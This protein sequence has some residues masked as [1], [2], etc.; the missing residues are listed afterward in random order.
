MIFDNLQQF[1]SEI[2]NYKVVHVFLDET[3]KDFS[4][5]IQQIEGRVNITKTIISPCYATEPLAQNLLYRGEDFVLVMGKLHLQSIAKF[6][7]YANN[8]SYAIVPI[9]EVA[10]YTFSKYAFVE[11]KKFCFYVCEKPAFAYISSEYFSQE[12]VFRLEKILSYKNIV[13]YEKE[14]QQD[15][16]KQSSYNL[17]NVVKSVNICDGTYRSVLKIY[18]ALSMLV[19]TTS[20]TDFLGNEY[21][22]LALL[23]TNKKDVTENLI[24]ANNL[25]ARFYECFNKFPLM[26]I[27]PDYNRHI[28]A[29]KKYYAL[30]LS[31]THQ[32][33]MNIFSGADL[34]T[35]QYTIKAYE[36]HLKVCFNNAKTHFM[37]SKVPLSSDQLEHALALGADLCGQK[38]LLRF[39]RD[40]GYFENL[41]K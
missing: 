31:Q 11:D 21:C 3:A 32:H 16:L 5:L 36:P 1:L 6:Y 14:W 7:C 15:I 18:G 38:T 12:D 4:G 26:N 28:S 40:M 33:M 8:L 29:L 10:E 20:T 17:E 34:K 23:N 27:M 39:A 37:F 9:K 2:S 41:L 35:I 13:Q 22:V 24:C 30:D 19:E 25:L